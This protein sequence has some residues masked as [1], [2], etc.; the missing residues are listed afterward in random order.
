MA[1][2]K[3]SNRS[4]LGAY[5]TGGRRFEILFPNAAVVLVAQAVMIPVALLT[6][7]L[8]DRWGRKP[9]FAVGFMAL[10]SRIFLYSLT[11]NPN[12]LIDEF[13]PWATQIEAVDAKKI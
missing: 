10:P 9:I 2:G 8:Y 7:W 5:S 6:G 11:T 13:F 4:P 12:M 3:S 1:R